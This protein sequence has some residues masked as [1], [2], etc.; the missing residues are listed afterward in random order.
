[1]ALNPW[2]QLANV[3]SEPRQ[4]FEDAVTTLLRAR[5]PGTRRVLVYKGDGGVDAF[6][7]KYGPSESVDVFQI[8]YLP[9]PWS[10]SQRE[11]IREA[12]ATAQNNPDFRLK[13]WRLC[14]PTRL[15]STDW[16]WFDTWRS[17]Q[18]D[19]DIDVVDGDELTTWLQ[20]PVCSEARDMLGK[21][22]VQGM[23]AAAHLTV[24][25]EVRARQ[26][27]WYI[28]L[29]L[30]NTGDRT[31]RSIRATI[32][33]SETQCIAAEADPQF[34]ITTNARQNPRQLSARLNL[35]PGENIL[36]L[37]IPLQ[38]APPLPLSVGAQL[39]AEDLPAM[40]YDF[41]VDSTEIR[42]HQTGLCWQHR[43]RLD[44]VPQPPPRAEARG[45]L[46]RSILQAVRNDT[47][48]EQQGLT[49]IIG[50]M[51]GIRGVAVYY[52]STATHGNL[53]L[54][55]ASKRDFAQA[56]AELLELGWLRELDEDHATRVY[57][58]VPTE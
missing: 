28:L 51:P 3:A 7:G 12:F 55:Q 45:A 9:A 37:A 58:F 22:G 42:C 39:W 40:S 47:A 48:N 43:Q 34:W 31:A 20:A 56:L 38:P 6:Q 8:K 53:P 11:Q 21:W 26:G 24:V 16:R 13:E 33:H 1:M 46:A 15:T 44:A 30:R 18:A 52:L 5:F 10:D 32:S 50:G 23:A 57:E 36:L 49:E 25:P 14:V 19:A 4:A 41:T 54:H 29:F 35:N 17:K 2:E 27:G